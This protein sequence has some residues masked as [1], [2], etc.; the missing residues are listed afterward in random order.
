MP[1]Q[2]NA[3]KR[4]FVLVEDDIQVSVVT[5][6]EF[7]AKKSRRKHPVEKDFIE[8]VPGVKI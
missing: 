8:S 5:Q 6:K 7:E 2:P 3:T 1:A 4:V